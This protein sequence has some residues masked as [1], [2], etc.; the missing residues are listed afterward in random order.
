MQLTGVYAPLVTPFDANP[1][2]CQ[3]HCLH[4]L[5]DEGQQSFTLAVLHHQHLVGARLNQ[6][7]DAAQGLFLHIHHFEAD[8]VGP[9]ILVLLRRRQMA[10]RSRSA[11]PARLAQP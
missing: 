8:Q 2:A 3:I 5:C 7:L 1:P 9:V 6:G 11:R 10:I 4:H